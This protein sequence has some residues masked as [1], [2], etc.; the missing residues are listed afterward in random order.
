MMKRNILNGLLVT[1]GAA[2][3]SAP[4]I[5]QDKLA[6]YEDGARVMV[7]GTVSDLS[8]DE[9]TLNY[10]GGSIG[11]EVDDWDWNWMDDSDL[12]SRLNNGDQI[13]VSGEIDDDWFEAREIEADNIYFRQNYSYYYVVD[14]NPAYYA[15]FD[16]DTAMRDGSY[17]SVR[18][19]VQNISG[20]EFTV[21]SQG[22]DLQIDTSDLSY[23]P[24]EGNSPVKT[25]DWVYV[26]GEVDDGFFDEKE[27]SAEAVVKINRVNRM[28]RNNTQNTNSGQM[29][30]R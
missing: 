1:A 21:R 5:A 27:L 4:A 28:A 19:K 17:L 25:G 23:N 20:R 26:Y 8:D 6:T 2:L 13:I 3:L 7:S 12:T 14:T 11:V 9:F 16:N 10:S 29:Q 24:M 18:G 22:T 15:E 30:R